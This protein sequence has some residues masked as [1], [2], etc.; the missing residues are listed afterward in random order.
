MTLKTNKVFPAV[1]AAL[2][3]VTGFINADNSCCPKPCCEKCCPCPNQEIWGCECEAYPCS[4]RICQYTDPT[5][6]EVKMMDSLS[7]F[8]VN[9]DA[10]GW[11]AQMDGLSAAIE[12]TVGTENFPQS[13]FTDARFEELKTRWRAG[14]RAGVGYYFDHDVWD[15]YACYTYYKGH[16]KSHENSGTPSTSGELLFANWSAASGPA[17]TQLP[18]TVTSFHQK[19]EARLNM[20]DLEL[21]R[22]FRAGKWLVLRPFVGGRGVWLKQNVDIDY[23]GATGGSLVTLTQPV[24]LDVDMK[25]K[26]SGG[27]LRAGLNS[28]WNMG[29]GFGLYGNGAVSILYGVFDIDQNETIGEGSCCSSADVILDIEDSFKSSKAVLDLQ[30]G[31]RWQ[32]FF[33]NSNNRFAVLAGWEQHIFI[34]QNQLKRFHSINTDGITFANTATY[35]APAEG[36]FGTEGFMLSV[37][38]EF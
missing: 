5:T 4:P 37:L 25:N 19:W 18:I 8:I 7:G 26:F 14:V 12:Q 38:F 3:A 21:G 28:E 32:T 16:A 10:L 15:V 22:R 36:D 6:C 33:C 35:F 34:N 29:C 1:S 30:L 23:F 17:S 11:R 20:V 27:G 13:R 24:S 31:I 9:V 2:L